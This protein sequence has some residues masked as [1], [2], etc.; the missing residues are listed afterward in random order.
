MF[1]DRSFYT[2]KGQIKFDM[3]VEDTFHK[4]LQQIHHVT[5]HV[6]DSIMGV[7][8]SIHA[9]VWGF[10]IGGMDILKNILVCFCPCQSQ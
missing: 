3:D 9:L 4:M 1:L 5:P 6:A 7:Y 8:P 2:E 10:K